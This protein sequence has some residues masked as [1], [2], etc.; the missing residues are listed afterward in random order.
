MNK[1]GFY[2]LGKT[3]TIALVAFIIVSIGSFLPFVRNS[4][5]AGLSWNYWILAGIAIVVPLYCII[6]DAIKY[7]KQK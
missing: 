6:T 1:K 3:N 4:Y 7:S 2:P 5:A